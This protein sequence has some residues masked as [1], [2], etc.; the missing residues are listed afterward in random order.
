MV[1]QDSNHS[2]EHVSR[3]LELYSPLVAPGGYLIVNDTNINGH[4][5]EEDIG[6]GPLEAVQ[7]FLA[8]QPEWG[9]RR[10]LR[11]LPAYFRPEQVA[12]SGTDRD[13]QEHG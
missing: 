5:V 6:P 11:A 2:V 9:D 3:E 10:Q 1:L 13:G 7:G 12:R 8:S 4:P